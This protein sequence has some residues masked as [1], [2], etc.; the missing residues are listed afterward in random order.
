MKQ[1][2]IVNL[3]QAPCFQKVFLRNSRCVTVATI[4]TIIKTEIG[5]YR[6]T[7]VQAELNLKWEASAQYCSTIN[8]TGEALAR[9]WQ[10]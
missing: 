3:N 1:A 4:T 9:S 5:R 10:T 7:E 6:C 2:G 8:A